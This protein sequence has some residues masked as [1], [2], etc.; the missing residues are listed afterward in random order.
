MDNKNLEIMTYECQVG[1][2]F[3][4]I[5]NLNNGFVVYSKIV[6][7]EH[8][9]F[10]TGFSAETI[11]DFEGA[12]N[13][14]KLFFKKIK[15]TP[16]FLISP[17]VK[18]SKIVEDYLNKKY[19]KF[20]VDVT[21]STEEL[22]SV[23]EIPEQYSFKKIDNKLEK[24]LFVQTFKTSKTQVLDGDTYGVLS[25]FYFKALDESFKNNSSWEYMHFLSMFN[26]SPVGM[27]SAVVNGEYCGLYG[28]G[29]YVSHRG[30]G[31]FRKLLKFVENELKNKGV[32]YFFLITEKNSKNEKLYNYLG[33]KSHFIKKYYK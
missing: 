8:W 15:R 6:E 4:G 3:S 30:K 9:N 31:V 16:C 2:Y 29:T 10:F 21:M 1:M 23:N 33:F 24:N 17:S 5:E 26:N 14:A 20:S 18:I 19:N 13:E 27:I 25:E 28:G 7:D 32:N 12:Y 11:E 22:K